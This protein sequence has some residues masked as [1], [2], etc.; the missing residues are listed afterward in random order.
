M[1]KMKFAYRMISIALLL[2]SQIVLAAPPT[3]NLKDIFELALQNDPTWA[4]S[5]YAN[6]AAQ[7][8]LIQGRALLL[9][10]I[11]ISGSGNRSI[12]DIQYTGNTVFKNDN[13]SDSFNTLTYGLNVNQPLFRKQNS[14][15][16]QESAIQ[17][18]LADLQL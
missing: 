10:T 6:T 13:Q 18:D 9:P 14:V 16:Y 3:Q 15:Q 1:I 2:T 4:A 12:T 5:R 8:K 7:E 17:V 11:S